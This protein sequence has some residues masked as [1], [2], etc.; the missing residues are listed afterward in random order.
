MK[1]YSLPQLSQIKSN[2][3]WQ[4]ANS[5][6]C[7]VVGGSK[8][9]LAASFDIFRRLLQIY[10][11]NEWQ[12]GKHWITTYWTQKRWWWLNFM[13]V[14]MYV[15]L[16]LFSVM[17]ANF[18]YLNKQIRIKYFN[19]T[20]SIKTREVHEI[21]LCTHDGNIILITSYHHFKNSQPCQPVN[22]QP[23]NCWILFS[24]IVIQIPKCGLR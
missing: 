24:K 12:H 3:R 19:Y 8:L 18:R 16:L 7:K 4:T 23:V 1:Y 20:N 22:C 5:S 11:Y 2:K 6:E 17:Q 14:G 10:P 9:N 15:V 13:Q 21:F